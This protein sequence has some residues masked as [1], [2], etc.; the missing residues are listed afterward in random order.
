[1]PDAGYI[2]VGDRETPLKYAYSRSTGSGRLVTVAAAQPILY[3]GETEAKSKAGFDVALATF[4]VDAAGKGTMGDLAPAATVKVDPNN[5]IV[6][7]DY[8]AEAVRL[9]GIAKK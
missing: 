5:A 8:G 1:M 6:V 9:T 4:E 7:Q 2:R 3:V